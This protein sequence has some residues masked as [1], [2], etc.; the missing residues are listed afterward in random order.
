[1]VGAI[2]VWRVRISTPQKPHYTHQLPPVVRVEGLKTLEDGTRP[3]CHAAAVHVDVL[4][5]DVV[6]VGDQAGV[7][8]PA[9]S[10]NMAQ[11]WRG[12]MRLRY[13]STYWSMI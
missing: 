6:G 3:A 5:H 7:R 1:M 4:V 2:S 8:V 10:V 13:M 12:A 11:V 9:R